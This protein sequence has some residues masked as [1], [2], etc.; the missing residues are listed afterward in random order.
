MM[1]KNVI[2]FCTVNGVLL[3]ACI[4]GIVRNRSIDPEREAPSIS[5]P[6]I[7]RV[8]VLNGYGGAGIAEKVADFLRSRNFD[9]KNIGNAQSFN[10]PFTLIV[11]R[12]ADMTIARQI[13]R[14]LATDHVV[15]IRNGEKDYD[16]TVVIG[17]DYRERIR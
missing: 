12:T 16:V 7:G 6:Y 17:P 14:A 15:L 5:V 1:P 11:S 10:Y 4:I 2:T 13:A 8:Q 9:V 3:I